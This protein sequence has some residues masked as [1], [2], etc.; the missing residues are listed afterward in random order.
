VALKEEVVLKE[1]NVVK[2][3]LA[4]EMDVLDKEATLSDHDE[5]YSAELLKVA[6][7]LD[8]DESAS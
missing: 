8:L 3:E 6:K 4:V 1:G 7:L 5:D 2:E